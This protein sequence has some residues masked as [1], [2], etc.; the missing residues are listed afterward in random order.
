MSD[1]GGPD[2]D[3]ASHV[4]TSPPSKPGAG[5]HKGKPTAGSG[6]ELPA[7]R[8]SPTSVADISRED[9]PSVP[10]SQERHSSLPSA[11]NHL[12]LGEDASENMALVETGGDLSPDTDP[13]AQQ[14]PTLTGLA[15]PQQDVVDENQQR[16][17]SPEDRGL[18]DSFAVNPRSDDDLDDSFADHIPSAAAQLGVVSDLSRLA[19]YGT[20][21]VKADDL[22]QSPGET[23]DADATPVP[24]LKSRPAQSTAETGLSAH[25][26]FRDEEVTPSSSNASAEEDRIT[27]IDQTHQVSAA[28]LPPPSRSALLP[29]PS[30]AHLSRPPSMTT[31]APELP[32]N[33]AIEEEIRDDWDD[34]QTEVFDRELRLGPLGLAKPATRSVPA[35]PPPRMSRP[36]APVPSNSAAFFSATAT[37]PPGRQSHRSAEQRGSVPPPTANKKP[38]LWGLIAVLGIAAALV[39]V[40]LP[41][42]GGLVVTAAGPGNSPL[43]NIEV[44]VDGKLVCSTSPCRLSDYPAGAHSVKARASGF[45]ETAVAAVLVTSGQDAV[46]NITLTP[47]PGTG[48]Q[49]SASGRGHVLLV[50]GEE[51][52]E[53][54]QELRNLSEGVH[55]IKIVSKQYETYTAEVDVKDR[56]MEVIGPLS[57]RVLQG[58]AKLEAGNNVQGSRIVLSVDGDRRTIPVADLPMRLRLN[59]SQKHILTATRRGHKRFRQELTFEDGQAE[60]SFVISLISNEST[61]KTND[62]T[63]RAPAPKRRVTPPPKKNNTRS[64]VTKKTATL[65]INSIPASK[66][67]VNGRPLGNTPKIGVKVNA[68]RVAVTFIKDGTKKTKSYNLKPGATVTATHR[69]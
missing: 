21:D 53:L 63:K 57:L 4:E 25:D 31:T 62:S 12:S 33:I 38:L 49:V 48:F 54:P 13:N 20:T 50:D 45:Q 1:K 30:I 68:G 8:S 32:S 19:G 55:Q 18:E 29:P 14:P 16:A 58:E 42:T 11:P 65:N 3:T 23:G 40:L 52:G 60:R 64:Q 56:I 6:S 39:F 61:T 35:P 2:S 41:R 69:F 22:V 26:P 28:A 59:T 10:A 37:R 47:V 43:E 51:V 46:Y 24:G 66:V 34:D 17:A 27:P 15:E 44:I 67:L 5:Y 7:R 36:T 9:V